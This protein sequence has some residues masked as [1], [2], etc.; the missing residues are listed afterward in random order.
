MKG[1]REHREQAIL[2]GDAV[3]EQGSWGNGMILGK[4]RTSHR[5]RDG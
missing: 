2:V 1:R 4:S 5:P 3:P